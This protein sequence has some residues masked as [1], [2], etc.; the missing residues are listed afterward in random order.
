M[1]RIHRPQGE[2]KGINVLSVGN[3]DISSGNILKERRKK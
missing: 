3:W 2:R 1:G